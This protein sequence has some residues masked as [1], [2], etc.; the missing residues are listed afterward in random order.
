MGVSLA[1]FAAPHASSR[2]ARQPAGQPRPTRPSL[3]DPAASPERTQKGQD[4]RLE[5]DFGSRSADQP[6]GNTSRRWATRRTPA[7]DK[8]EA[9]SLVQDT[10]SFMGLGGP[11]ELAH[12][13]RSSCCCSSPGAGTLLLGRRPRSSMTPKGGALALPRQ[14][15]LLIQQWHSSS[16]RRIPPRLGWCLVR[17]SLGVRSRQVGP[18]IP[19]RPDSSKSPYSYCVHACPTRARIPS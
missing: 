10:P 3:A 1:R 15:H 13:C 11:S 7:A 8:R 5:R 9:G 4:R 6:A 16:Q 19:A 2:P 17:S 14:Q 18:P 12:R